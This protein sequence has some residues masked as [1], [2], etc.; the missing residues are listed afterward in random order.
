MLLF[1]FEMGSAILAS[2]SLLLRRSILPL[3]ASSLVPPYDVRRGPIFGRVGGA[4]LDHDWGAGEG[5]EGAG[6]QTCPILKIMEQSN[7]S[8]FYIYRQ[9]LHRKAKINLTPMTAE[10]A[11]LTRRA[12]WW[13]QPGD[14]PQV[15]Q[16]DVSR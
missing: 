10:G 6:S 11:A 5:E 14:T 13:R 3:R 12:R 15:E 9:F 7:T 16:R 2:A 8:I 1:F 4:G